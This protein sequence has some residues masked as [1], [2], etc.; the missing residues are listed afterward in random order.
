MSPQHQ[1]WKYTHTH[2]QSRSFS[3]PPY[4]THAAWICVWETGESPRL[5]RSSP[6]PNHQQAQINLSAPETCSQSLSLSLLRYAW[7]SRCLCSS[8]PAIIF[9]SCLAAL[10]LS[11]IFSLYCHCHCFYIFLHI[12]LSPSHSLFPSFIP[13]AFSYF[14]HSIYSFDVYV[15]FFNIFLLVYFSSLFNLQQYFH[16]PNE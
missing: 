3:L 12:V 13:T 4:H 15:S 11:P 5:C 10:S 6:K 8:S 7:N 14:C 2:T 1:Q 9:V 16:W